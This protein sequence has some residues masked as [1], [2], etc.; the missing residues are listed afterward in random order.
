MILTV[1]RRAESHGPDWLIC[2]DEEG[3]KHTVDFLVDG[4]LPRDTLASDLI[5]KRIK[6]DYLV[7]YQ[8]IAAYPEIIIEEPADKATSE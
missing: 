8:E 6:V 1:I 5:G 2:E 4:A 7:P 3:N